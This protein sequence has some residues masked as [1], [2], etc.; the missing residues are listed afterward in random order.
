MERYNV[1][2]VANHFRV[3]SQTIYR[4]TED[5]KNFMSDS[6]HPDKK[7]KQYFYTSDDMEV[8]SLLDEMRSIGRTTQEIIDALAKGERGRFAELNSP[9]DITVSEE[10]A[11]ELRDTF[12]LIKGERDKALVELQDAKLQI[13]QL[14]SKA[15]RSDALEG[16]LKQ[17]RIELRQLERTIGGLEAKL[18]MHGIDPKTGKKLAE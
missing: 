8:F 17:V 12:E 3:T 6:A 13:A 2:E 14:Q 4:W 5:C 10:Q 16:E 1:N 9:K 18:E 11:F 15:Q 7:G